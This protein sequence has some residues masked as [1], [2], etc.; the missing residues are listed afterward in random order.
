[1]TLIAGKSSIV[2]RGGRVP[3][4]GGGEHVFRGGR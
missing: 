1:V 4:G 2:P 3:A